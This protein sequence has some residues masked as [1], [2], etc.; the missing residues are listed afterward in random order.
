MI[1]A[2]LLTL[3]PVLGLVTQMHRVLTV[4]LSHKELSWQVPLDIS[5]HDLEQTSSTFCHQVTPKNSTHHHEGPLK[6][7]CHLWAMHVT[8]VAMFSSRRVT[9][10]TF[11]CAGMTSSTAWTLGSQ[12]DWDCLCN[13]WLRPTMPVN[14][15]LRASPSSFNICMCVPGVPRPT[16]GSRP[17]TRATAWVGPDEWPQGCKSIS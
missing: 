4:S 14:V 7:L 15:K 13:K 5:K 6:G 11:T 9:T 3:A 1:P 10:S 16:H 17:L 12:L 2:L 8:R